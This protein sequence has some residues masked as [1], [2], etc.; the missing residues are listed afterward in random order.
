MGDTPCKWSGYAG[1]VWKGQRITGKPGHGGVKRWGVKDV[2]GGFASQ[3]VG[4]RRVSKPETNHD[5]DSIIQDKRLTGGFGGFHTEPL[6]VKETELSNSTEL[7]PG[8]PNPPS[9]QSKS[10]H[11]RVAVR[12]W[13]PRLFGDN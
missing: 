13:H 12:R 4:L 9:N 2:D 8:K 5:P 1:R 6:H 11:A 3:A 10:R 7:E